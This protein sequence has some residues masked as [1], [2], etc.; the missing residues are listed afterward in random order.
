MKKELMAKTAQLE[1]F[2][3]ALYKIV[4]KEVAPGEQEPDG[5]SMYMIATSEQPISAFHSGEWFAEPEKELPKRYAGQSTC[6]RK[7]AGSAGRD[8]WGIFRVHQFEKVEQFSITTPDKSWEEHEFMLKNAEDFYSSLG[9]PY[10]VVSIVSGALNNAASKK[11][12]LEAWFPFQTEY[13]EL[14][15]CS[16]CLDYQ[17]RRLDIRVGTKKL[18]DQVKNY[19]HCLNCTLV[20]TERAMCCVLE[21]YQTNEGVIVPEVLRPYIGGKEFIPFIKDLSG[22]KVLFLMNIAV[23]QILNT[24]F[25][26]RTGDKEMKSSMK[27]KKVIIRPGNA[28]V[29]LPKQIFG[30]LYTYPDNPRISKIQIAA[31]YVNLKL[32]VQNLIVGKDTTTP[33]FLSKFPLGK[34]PVFEGKN[35]F[36]LFESNAI[37]HYIADQSSG[38]LLGTSTKENALI[39]QF[40]TLC[41]NEF[42][43]AEAVWL[44]PLF[45][46]IPENPTFTKKAK[47]DVKKA[48]SLLEA[49]L[50]TKTYLVGEAITLADIAVAT[51]LLQYYIYVFDKV[52]R[53]EFKN[54][55]RWFITCINQKEFL[56][57]LGEVK[58]CEIELTIKKETEQIVKKSTISTATSKFHSVQKT[59]LKKIGSKPVTLTIWKSN[60]PKDLKKGIPAKSLTSLPAS[61][62]LTN[63]QY[64]FNSELDTVASA[65]KVIESLL[66]E[67]KQKS[68]N[69][70]ASLNIIGDINFLKIEGFVAVVG[71]VEAKKVD[72][73]LENKYFLKVEGVSTASKIVACQV[74]V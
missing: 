15:S 68:E 17:S 58:L 67:F 20:A 12:D 62:I 33:E 38:H 14:V 28:G 34:L 64:R 40:I 50:L 61:T 56:A 23:K 3:E 19:V 24:L 35:G 1:E 72:E 53:N 6:F 10:R 54:V 31:A 70:A 73:F 55:T 65:N 69:V 66:L 71:E 26:T 59:E 41:E 21:N 36:T 29:G 37:A 5:N 9:I 13:K 43:P 42:I 46:W 74:F 30:T 16:N 39:F 27:F 18:N 51:S 44:F 63:V 60:L 25:P 32:D 11:Y 57:V 48:L 2:D 7:E 22:K 52:W 49:H 8:N 47:L 4:Q 45:G